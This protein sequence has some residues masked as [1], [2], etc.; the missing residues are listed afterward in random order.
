M[1]KNQAKQNIIGNVPEEVLVLVLLH[2]NYNLQ[3]NLQSK[4]TNENNKLYKQLQTLNI[5]LNLFT[6]L[7]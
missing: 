1:N 5:K 4:K 2:T 6:K 7:H 3:N